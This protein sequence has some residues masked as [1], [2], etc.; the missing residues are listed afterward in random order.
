MIFSAF[1][2]DEKKERK[3]FEVLFHAL[4]WETETKKDLVHV[5]EWK[6]LY[7]DFNL[8]F[9]NYWYSGYE[10]RQLNCFNFKIIF[11]SQIGPRIE[12]MKTF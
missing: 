6:I 7:S 11:K 1:E 10:L 5:Y 8:K 2:K 9:T 12:D 3:I 4:V